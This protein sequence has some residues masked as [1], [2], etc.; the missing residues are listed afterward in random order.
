MINNNY[1]SELSNLHTDVYSSIGEPV[2]QP[3][4][5]GSIID[6]LSGSDITQIAI[7]AIGALT[8]GYVC[9]KGSSLDINYGDVGIS[10][11]SPNR[12]A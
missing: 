9:S 10:L 7:A 4:T 5:T 3:M 2:L 11:S 1:Y 8:L 6:K 12:T